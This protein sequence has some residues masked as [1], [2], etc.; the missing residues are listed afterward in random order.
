M[1]TFG[2]GMTRGSVDLVSGGSA[3]FGG[4]GAS[5]GRDGRSQ[6]GARLVSAIPHGH[7]KTTTLSP[8]CARRPDRAFVIDR[9]M[10]GAIFL[11]Y[12][13]RSPAPP[14]RPATSS[15]WTIC[16]PT[17]CWCASGDPRQRG[18][19]ALPT[20]PV[21]PGAGSRR[22]QPERDALRQAQSAAAQSRRTLDPGA[23]DRWRTARPIPLR[24]MPP[25]S[26]HAG[27]V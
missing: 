21:Q 26:A 6:R 24:R 23:V 19:T 12:I 3:R 22:S 4:S 9:P 1:P 10:N 25:L 15:S 20:A 11:A 17:R 18:R 8:D 7:W 2:G 27:Y 14:S 5:N 16:R 13:E